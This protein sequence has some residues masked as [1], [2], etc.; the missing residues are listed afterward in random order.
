MR[1]TYRTGGAASYTTSVT[2]PADS[3]NIFI[4]TAQAGALLF[5]APSGTPTEGQV[6]EIVIKDNNTARA[7]TWNAIFDWSPPSTTILGKWKKMFF[8]WN[9]TTSKWNFMRQVD[10][11]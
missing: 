2:I 4:I 7:L 9:A 11:P 6:L 1:Y 3:V 8:Q 10:E 5:N